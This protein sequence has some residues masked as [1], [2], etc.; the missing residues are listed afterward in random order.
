MELRGLP[1][2]SLA[3]VALPPQAYPVDSQNMNY[4]PA[5]LVGVIA[6]ALFM[7]CVEHQKACHTCD[8]WLIH[9]KAVP[10]RISACNAHAQGLAAR[11]H[12]PVVLCFPERTHQH[13]HACILNL[14][15]WAPGIGGTSW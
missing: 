2:L 3:V 14:R 11:P 7:W 9:A 8:A 15:R 5:M 12:F 4:A 10:S 6:F 13:L 1:A